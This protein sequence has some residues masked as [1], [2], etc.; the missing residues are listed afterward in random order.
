[1]ADSS[2]PPIPDRPSAAAD[3]ALAAAVDQ[4]RRN[5]GGPSGGASP[6][7]A[8][9]P[10]PAHAARDDA[11]GRLAALARLQVALE[12]QVRQAAAGAAA[13]GA[14]YSQLGA[15]W[16]IS[17]QGARQ[18][19]PGLVFTRPQSEPE[20]EPELEPESDL[21]EGS[22]RVNATA[23][24]TSY[25]VLLVED[26]D[27]DAML[28]EEALVDRGLARSVRR[29]AD[30]IAALDYLRDADNP[31]PDLIVL[32]LNM[33]RMNG[34][35]LLTVLKNDQDLSTVPVVVLTTSAAPDDVNGAYQG[36]ANAYVTKPVNL[37]DFIH[38]VQSI[39]AFFLDTATGPVADA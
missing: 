30:G 38:A 34:R 23:P 22:P 26:D 12:L 9:S 10:E 24:P 28:I 36:H 16:N 29:A 37:D 31:R 32:D 35:E 11:L 17:R 13:A 1:M 8:S 15:A 4:L 39:D 25:T 33:P 7:P 21:T 14:N 27:A 6:E 20:L 18:R 5:G 19:W 2:Q 3:E